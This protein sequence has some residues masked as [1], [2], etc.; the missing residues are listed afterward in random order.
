M[1]T[2]ASA[3][4]MHK[5]DW[6]TPTTFDPFKPINATV[7]DQNHSYN[8]HIYLIYTIDGINPR[9][10]TISLWINT[11]FTL[12]DECMYSTSCILF[13]WYFTIKG[14]K[15]LLSVRDGSFHSWCGLASPLYLWALQI[16]NLTHCSVHRNWTLFKYFIKTLL[17]CWY[18]TDLGCLMRYL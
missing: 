2:V 10:Y 12:Y 18:N 4:W 13:T 15:K 1:L 3:D 14:K 7:I 8:T 5:Q 6:K 9:L 11:L 17:F 16:N